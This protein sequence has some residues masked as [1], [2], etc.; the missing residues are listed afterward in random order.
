[1]SLLESLLDW[2]R[3]EPSRIWL[4]QPT[5]EGDR[6]YSFAAAASEVRRIAEA[7]NAWDL[8]RGSRIAI[9]GRNTAH[10]FMVDLAISM[11]GHVAVGMYPRQ[12]KPAIDFIFQ[13]AEISHVFLGPSLLAGDA[14]E[15]AAALPSGVV[16]VAMPYPGVPASTL[17][18]DAFIAQRKPLDPSLRAAPDELGMLVY[19]SG[20]SGDPKGVMLSHQN[21][22]WAVQNVLAYGM[23]V[24]RQEVFLSYL[25][26]A[27]LMERIFG[28]A[29]SVTIGAE[30]HFLEKPELLA[31][32]LQKV[33]P[34]RFAGVP[35]VYQRI[36]AGVL[37][38][39]PQAKLDRL[40]GI[41]LVGKWFKGRIRRKMGLQRAEAPGVGAAAM[42]KDQIDWFEKLGIQLYQGYGMTENCA[43]TALEKP[44]ARRAG[45]VGKPLP[46]SGFRL[47]IE[48]EIQVKHPG[49]MLGY[50]KDPE[51]TRQAF[52]EDG[53]LRT[54]DRGRLDNDGYL[55]V[56]GRLKDEFKTGKGKYVV[57]AI[58]EDKLAR[59]TDLEHVCVL[60]VGLNQPI[61]LATLNEKG[62][63]RPRAELQADL[64]RDLRAVNASLEDHER[65][66][67]CLV[68]GETWSPMNGFTTP[69]GKLKRTTVE[70]HY[71]D[72]IKRI[73]DRRDPLVKW[74][75]ELS[76]VAPASHVAALQSN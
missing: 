30:V 64:E 75:D 70:S 3:R 18:W 60:G 76:K 65:I 38:K 45:S 61:L 12:G 14:E 20:T 21:V 16:S 48:G 7:I 17:T 68:V 39:L 67:Q 2:E 57:P 5:A 9:S 69:T 36:Q 47:S 42:P 58:I 15:F 44:G 27:H 41:P 4:V 74:A 22:D 53:W 6:S 23:S 49:V 35:L 43:Y 34:T 28:E 11:A 50:F 13:H 73:A 55:F 71:A 51:R 54:G 26:L 33:A 46:G 52:T 32:T 31:A 29:M 66:A 63:G 40:L 56:T 37:S 72:A 25:P 62:R 19:T 1:M 24:Q 8:P 10:W 59:N